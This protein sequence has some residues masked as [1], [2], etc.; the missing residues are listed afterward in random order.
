MV[1][2]KYDFY[3]LEKQFDSKNIIFNEPY[4]N[5]DDLFVKIKMINIINSFPNSKIYNLFIENTIEEYKFK[6][7]TVIL[8]NLKNKN[9]KKSIII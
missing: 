6:K 3:K 1:N 4:H 2:Y 7:N 8:N 9:K 5:K